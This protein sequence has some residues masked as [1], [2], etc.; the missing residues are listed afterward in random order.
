MEMEMAM[1]TAMKEYVKPIIKIYDIQ[2]GDDKNKSKAD[3]INTSLDYGFIYK[4]I[5]NYN[6]VIE[7][8][9]IVN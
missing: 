1:E 6:A 9:L 4:I 5:N 7:D 2:V 8:S 3:E